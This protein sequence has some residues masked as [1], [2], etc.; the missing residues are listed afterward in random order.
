MVVYERAVG[1]TVEWY[2]P[3]SLFSR[4]LLY[5]DLDP[6]CG[7]TRCVV[8][9]RGPRHCL[10]ENGASVPWE[11]RVWLNPPHGPAALPFISRMVE[12]RNGVLLSAARTETRWFQKAAASADVV[13]FLADRLHFVRDDGLQARSSFASVLM[14]WGPTPASAVVDSDLGWWVRG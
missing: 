9:F 13:C 11:G 2:T 4:L 12:H 10:A 14:A 7:G 6:A 5:F 8:P 1:A 3:P